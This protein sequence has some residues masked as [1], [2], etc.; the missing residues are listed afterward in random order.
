MNAIRHILANNASPMTLDGT[1]TYI[2]GSR[3]V[4]VIDAGPAEDAHLDAVAAAIGAAASVTVVNTHTHADHSEGAAALATR[5]GTEPL[6]VKDGQVILTDA[7]ELHALATPGHTS[8]HFCF[9][10]SRERAL[11][12][13]DLMMGGLDTALVAPPEGDLQDYLNSLEK[14]RALG[15]RVIYPAH[16]EPFHDAEAAVSRYVEHRMER[17]QQVMTALKDGPATAEQLVDRIYGEQ[18][19]PA[20]RTYAGDAVLAY[21]LYLRNGGVVDLRQQRW[22]L[23]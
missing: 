4:V 19:D 14:I 21:L 20:L 9:F 11:F 8:D 7:G 23:V 12:C 15:C 18:L 22:E 13:G 2:I 5:F 16:G 3:Q 1:R 17:V 6:R 10:L